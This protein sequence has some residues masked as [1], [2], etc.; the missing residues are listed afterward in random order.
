MELLRADL[1]GIADRVVAALISCNIDI[2]SL[3]EGSGALAKVKDAREVEVLE[4]E[5]LGLAVLVVG[6]N[7]GS[8][9]ELRHEVGES[10]AVAV[11]SVFLV[12][13]S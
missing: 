11:L 6:G 1:L 7:H 12:S 13:N 5:G 8:T 10:I 2:A 4:V 3:V 9:R